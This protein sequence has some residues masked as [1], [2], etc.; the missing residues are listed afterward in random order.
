MWSKPEDRVAFSSFIK[1]LY[2]KCPDERIQRKMKLALFGE[3]GLL[4][5][6]R[7]GTIFASEFGYALVKSRDE[8][9]TGLCFRYRELARRGS[10][11]VERRRRR[12]GSALLRPG[13]LGSDDSV[14]C[15]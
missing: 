8:E 12:V 4:K 9:L 3:E 10:L 1:S 5:P 13:R 7:V 11:A 2:S 14:S 6:F 15:A